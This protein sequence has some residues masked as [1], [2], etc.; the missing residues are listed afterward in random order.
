MIIAMT[1]MLIVLTMIFS[2]PLTLFTTLFLSEYLSPKTQKIIT[3]FIQLLA[4]IPSIVFGIFARDQIGALFRLMGAPTNDNMMVA[5]LTLTFMAIP[6]MVSL[7]YNAI[8]SIPEGDR[9]GS[10][11][12]GISKQRTSFGIVLRSA[13]P[14]VISAIIL[15]MSRVIGETMAV[16][17]IA[18]NASGGFNNSSL[19]A[20]LFS[21]IRTLAS[22]IG[23]EFQ[24]AA[25][26]EHKAALFAIATFLFFLVLIINLTILLISNFS[27]YRDAWY[28]RRAEQMRSQIKSKKAKLKN[29]SLLNNAPIIY[30]DSQLGTMVNLKTEDKF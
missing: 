12:L 13:R 1:L 8:K 24:E 3:T 10:L 5:A 27:S 25:S 7:S 16:M 6:T 26:P 17:M 21:S 14:K 30:S 2:V 9:L 22:T 20:F 15:G 18:G 23:L 4:G 29:Y 11:A 19:G 28:V